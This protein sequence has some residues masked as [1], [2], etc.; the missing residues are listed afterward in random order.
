[1]CLRGLRVNSH[2]IYVNSHVI[3]QYVN[4]HV[5]VKTNSCNKKR[6]CWAP[7]QNLN[8]NYKKPWLVFD[9][10]ISQQVRICLHKIMNTRNEYKVEKDH[11]MK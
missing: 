9:T 1:M 6:T 3:S 5:I 11:A 4:S 10:T 8:V 2:V 7:T